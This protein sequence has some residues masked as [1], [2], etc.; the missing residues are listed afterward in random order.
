MVI[1]IAL[2]TFKESY[3]IIREN[4][5]KK[6]S[7]LNYFHG[8]DKETTGVDA[9]NPFLPCIADFSTSYC[10]VTESYNAFE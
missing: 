3:L 1:G 10:S 2:S 9:C 5:N 6:G 4:C 8:C 7:D